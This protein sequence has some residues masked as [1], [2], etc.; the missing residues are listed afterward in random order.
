MKSG[1]AIL[2]PQAEG[3]Q[4]LERIPQPFFNQLDLDA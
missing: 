4:I 2:K 3:S 1:S